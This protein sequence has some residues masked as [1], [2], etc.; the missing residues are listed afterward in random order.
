MFW[1]DCYVGIIGLVRY[2]NYSLSLIFW[3]WSSVTFSKFY[4]ITN[5]CYWELCKKWLL[6]NF[7]SI[8]SYNLYLNLNFLK[9]TLKEF[10]KV[11]KLH[12]F[13]LYLYRKIKPYTTILLQELWNFVLRVIFC[14]ILIM[15]L[16]LTFFNQLQIV[17]NPRATFL[18]FLY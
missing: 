17:I 1:F 7:K 13:S 5:A 18:H 6:L 8:M 15:K 4:K 16:T 3:T 10:D 14:L 9:N 2:D 12:P 11:A